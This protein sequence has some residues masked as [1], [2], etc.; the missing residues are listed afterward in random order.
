[1]LIPSAEMVLRGRW[2]FAVVAPGSVSRVAWRRGAKE[3]KVGPL[4]KVAIQQGDLL[5]LLIGPRDSNHSCDLTMIDLSLATPGADGKTWHLAA[6]LTP[7]VLAGNPHADRFGNAGVWHFYSEPDGGGSSGAAVIAVGS[8]LAKWQASGSAEEKRQL[9]EQL[10]A[11]LT[12]GAPPA[13]DSP[14]AKL[15]QQLTSLG[16]PLF[17]GDVSRLATAADEESA[18]NAGSASRF[19]LDAG[20]FGHSPDGRKI[21]PADLSVQAPAIIEIRLPAELAAGCEF[22]T[23]GMLDR[24]SGAEGSVQMQLLTT[25]PEAKTGLIASNTSIEQTGAAWVD[26]KPISFTAPMVVN[27]GSAA[28]R[29]VEAAFQAHRELFPAALCYTKIVPVD[30]V[31]TLTLFYREDD[32]LARLMLDANQ[33]AHLDRLWDELHFVS[34]DALTLVDAFEQIWQYSTQDGPDAPNGDKRLEP[35]RKPINDNAAALR[36]R[37]VT[38]EPRHVEA[39]LEFADRAFRRPLSAGEQQELRGL[40]QKLR[41]QELSHEEAMQ[42]TIARTLIAPAFLYR[43]ENPGDGKTQAPVSDSELASRL[44]Y[45]LWSSMP[46][47]ELRSLADSGKLRDPAVISAQTRRMLADERTR[48]LATEFGCQWLHI[49]DFDTLDEKSERHFPGLSSLCAARCMRSRFSSSRTSFKTIVRCST[50][51]TQIT[52]FSM[53]RSRSITGSLG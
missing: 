14:D 17:S 20:M 52:P 11:L 26:T 8:V 40:Y 45:F 25:K 5:S 27:E 49:R 24:Q 19:G 36:A 51:S 9:A 38:T 12:A 50:C 44:S 21:A 6:E 48:R 43:A 30:E 42:L 31:V 18:E 1:M 33:K 28:R 29:K 53:R 13:R 32:Q 22:V 39:A 4:E 15:Y 35:L 10:Q 37:L 16:G 41:S 23:T 2:N 46:D 7:D 47:A 3:V 34:R